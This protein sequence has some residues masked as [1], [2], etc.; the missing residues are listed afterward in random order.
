MSTNFKKNAEDF[1]CERCSVHVKGN[2]YT[3]HCPS[4]L[5]SKHV[6]NFPGDRG[7]TCGG[8]MEPTQCIFGRGQ[9]SLVHCC[10]KCGEEKKNRVLPEDNFDM[11]IAI[12]KTKSRK[13]F[14][15]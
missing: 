5:W 14:D 6:D 7:V 13:Y 11:A 15:M 10:T 1:I 9:Y 12:A 4:C 3:N 8:M 2:G